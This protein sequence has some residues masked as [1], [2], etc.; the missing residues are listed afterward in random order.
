MDSTFDNSQQECSASSPFEALVAGALV[1]LRFATSDVFHLIPD[2]MTG[3]RLKCSRSF[4]KIRI[5]YFS[6]ACDLF[7]PQPNW[8]INYRLNRV[9][10]FILRVFA[11]FVVY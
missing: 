11:V 10:M 7:V 5:V 6:N 9:A 8:P 3:E 4:Q 1:F 2:L